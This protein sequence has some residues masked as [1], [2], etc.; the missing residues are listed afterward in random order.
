M[1]KITKKTYALGKKICNDI[2]WWRVLHTTLYVIIGF[3][4]TKFIWVC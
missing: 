2:Y 1:N 4:V 3:I